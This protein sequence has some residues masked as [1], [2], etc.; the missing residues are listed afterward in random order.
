MYQSNLPTIFNFN[1]IQA[2]VHVDAQS[3][4]WFVVKD[5]CDILDISKYRDALNKLDEDEKGCPVK[6]D[7]LGG[8]Q[9]MATVN[10]SWLY[11]LK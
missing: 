3:D 1:S 4:L 2:R 10:E 5:V 7:T 6:V 11:T 8:Q 9:E